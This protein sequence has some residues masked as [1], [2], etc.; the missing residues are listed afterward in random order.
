MKIGSLVKFKSW[1]ERNKICKGI[2]PGIVWKVNYNVQ[3]GAASRQDTL[4]VIW[5]NQHKTAEYRYQVEM[6]SEGR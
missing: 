5:S 1:S 3:Y 4:F 2:P 6:I